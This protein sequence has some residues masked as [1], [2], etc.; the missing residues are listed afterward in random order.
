MPLLPGLERVEIQ[1]S[2]GLL[3]EKGR[4]KRRGEGL[5]VYPFG[6]IIYLL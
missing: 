2:L 3:G 4:W 1:S 5:L 6:I